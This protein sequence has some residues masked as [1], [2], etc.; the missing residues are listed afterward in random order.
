[1]CGTG[2]S[3]PAAA[4]THRRRIFVQL[5]LVVV[6][7]IIIIV[8]VV[9]QQRVSKLGEGDSA[10]TINVQRPKEFRAVVAQVLQSVRP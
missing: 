4:T 3:A 7:I 1:M 9:F 2:S 10:I 6:I 5:L 8:V